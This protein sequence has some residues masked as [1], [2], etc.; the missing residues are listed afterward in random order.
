MNL[1]AVLANL[2]LAMH[3]VFILYCI[4]GGVLVLSRHW[5]VVV[6][7]PALIWGAA[8]EFFGIICPYATTITISGDNFLKVLNSSS[9]S[10]LAG[11]LKFISFFLQKFSI[12][13]ELIFCPLFDFFGG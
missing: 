7:I 1:Y 4:F 2:A 10:R 6:H 12:G 5:T 3:G 8:T 9:L 13:E 11:L